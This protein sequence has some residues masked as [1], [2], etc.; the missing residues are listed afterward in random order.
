MKLLLYPNGVDTESFTCKDKKNI[1]EEYHLNHSRVIIYIGTTDKARY[2]NILIEAF[3]RVREKK[4][5]VK[6]LMIGEG[7]DKDNLAKLARELGIE[8][9]VIFTGQVSH[10][11]VPHFIAVAD[12]GVSPVPPLSFY[13]VT[14]PVKMLEYMSMAKPVIANSEI[15]E[16]KKILEQ[17]GGGILVPFASEAFAEALIEMLDN[18]E[19]RAEMG[20][21]GKEWIVKNRSYEVLARRL[22]EGLFELLK[23]NSSR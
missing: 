18:P 23:E 14:C 4:E 5:K 6:L 7:T 1:V 16:H 21:K 13:K 11:E 17:S 10:S 15:F 22:E 12:I 20:R 8:D 19:R 2:L 3:A 9:D